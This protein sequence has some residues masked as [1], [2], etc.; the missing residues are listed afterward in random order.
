M[1]D[2]SRRRGRRRCRAIGKPLGARRRA[3]R[4]RF[5]PDVLAFDE[6][7][8]DVKLYEWL[9]MFV[10]VGTPPAVID[11]ASKALQTAVSDAELK[12]TCD[13]MGM[14]VR[15][16]YKDGRSSFSSLDVFPRAEC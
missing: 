2:C 13:S 6:A 12:K 4:S 15:P 11:Q 7:G 10:P 8:I 9:G 5:T 16:T 1:H 14:E 3:R